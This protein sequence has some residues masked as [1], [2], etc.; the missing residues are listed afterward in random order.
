MKVISIINVIDEEEY[1]AKVLGNTVE[2]GMVPIVI[3]NGGSDRVLDIVREWGVQ[4]FDH[5]TPTFELQDLIS[6]GVGVAKSLGCDWY[7]LTDADEL[8]ETYDGR[9]IADVI[10]EEDAK[11][12][13]CINFD[14]YSFWATVDD[15]MDE[16]DF[17]KRILHYTFFDIPY[18]RAVKNSP[19]ITLDH[20]HTPGGELRLSPVS[21]VIRHYKF[22]DAD[23]G[24]RK[25]LAR[26]ARYDPWD[27]SQ[28]SHTHYKHIGVAD[29]Y[30][31]LVPAVYR[32]LN[33]FDGT[34]VRK[35][36]WDEWR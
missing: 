12:Y 27:L 1:I 7:V 19:E 4:I 25:V 5:I 20:P 29:G 30:Y 22:L 11:G 6:F 33:R 16:P 3:N 28:G 10:E 2:Q 14:S 34:W 32:K 21:M 26:R 13:N 17:A 23:Q 36:V 35:Q 24:R 18:I 9:T 8:M 31:V 15:D